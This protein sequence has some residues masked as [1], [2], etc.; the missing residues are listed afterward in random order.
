LSAGQLNG[1]VTDSKEVPNKDN[2]NTTYIFDILGKPVT[3]YEGVYDD[4]GENTKSLSID[5]AGTYKAF[6]IA[7]NIQYDNL[8]TGTQHLSDTLIETPT[9]PRQR[10][11]NVDITKI[12]VGVTDFVLSSWV[13]ADSAFIATERKT[14]YS[15]GKTDKEHIDNSDTNKKNRKFELRALLTYDKGNPDTYSASYDWLNTG[16]QYLALPVTI[17][18]DDNIGDRIVGTFPFTLGGENRKLQSIEVILDYSY[19]TNAIEF[20]CLTLRQ[21][22]WQYSEFDPDGKQVYSEDSESGLRTCYQYDND[23]CIK[24]II[25]DRLY[26]QFVNTY[27]YNKQGKPVRSTDYNGLVNETVYDDKGRA[28]KS[29]VYNLSDPTAKLYTEKEYDDKGVHTATL[30]ERGERTE[31]K[32]F[33]NQLTSDLLPNGASFNYGYDSLGNLN[34]ISSDAD[35]EPNTNKFGYT[36]GILTSVTSGNNEYKYTYNGWGQKTK[37]ELPSGDNYTFDSTDE[38]GN[39]TDTTTYHNITGAVEYTITRKIDKYGNTLE[40]D[41]SGTPQIKAEY[42]EHSKLKSYEDKIS[43]LTDTFTYDKAGRVTKK[44]NTKVTVNT[45][46]TDNK[47]TAVSIKLNLE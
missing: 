23:N 11:Y 6:S 22:T 46:Y 36:L 5:Y 14:D 30:D 38:P 31:H 44:S 35:G 3:V 37:T 45:D 43:N 2:L 28:V 20:N 21:G 39:S 17:N 18:E 4:I 27:E 16:W 25:T 29:F 10:K 8:L 24:A 42:D 41:L 40:A 15:Y 19:N 13:K 32:Y 47:A 33:K 12:P 34:S 1:T 26:Q 7:D 9:Q